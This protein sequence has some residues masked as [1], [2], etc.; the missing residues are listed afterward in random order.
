MLR[1]AAGA[2]FTPDE[3]AAAT[4]AAATERRHPGALVRVLFAECTKADAGYDAERINEAFTGMAEAEGSLLEELP[5]RLERFHYDLVATTTHHADEAQAY[6]AGRVP[7]VAMI[8]GPGYMELVHEVS[9]LPPG[10][11]VG[12]ICTS[13][14]G[15]E[16]ITETL[17]LA[18]N[19]TLEIISA[20]PD[21]TAELAAVDRDADLVLVSR[22]AFAAGFEASV[23]RP[24]R[25]RE[26]TYEFDPSGLEFLRRAIEHA[27][28]TREA[29]HLKRSEAASPTG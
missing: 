2:G 20:T 19:D 10:S 1:R 17:R 3:V 25:V 7:V 27:Q 28:A 29:T 23:D 26:W 12:V 11:R 6:V 13:A 9:A 22:E 5:E 14:R 24:E 18:G 15:V 16:S 4:F 8:V 21:S